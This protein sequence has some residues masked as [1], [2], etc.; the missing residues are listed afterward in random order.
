[1]PKT[2]KAQILYIVN[3][4]VVTSDIKK[5]ENCEYS[6][7]NIKIQQQKTKVTFELHAHLML[8]GELFPL[9]H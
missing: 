5:K 2:W 4:N 9:A 6:V 8:L 7:R 1:L 3:A